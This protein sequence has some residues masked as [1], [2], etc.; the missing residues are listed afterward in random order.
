ME[1]AGWKNVGR[2]DV[3]TLRLKK[4]LHQDKRVIFE[5]VIRWLERIRNDIFGKMISCY[6]FLFRHHISHFWGLDFS[7]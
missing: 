5:C 2:E 4:M 1:R 6:T 3:P 7:S